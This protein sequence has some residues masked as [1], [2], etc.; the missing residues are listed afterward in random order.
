MAAG[1]RP[2]PILAGCCPGPP[3]TMD[4]VTL[5]AY[6]FVTY[7]RWPSGVTAR[8]RAPGIEPSS[9]SRLPPFLHGCSTRKGS[10]LLSAVPTRTVTSLLRVDSGTVTTSARSSA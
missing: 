7:T 8:S 1:T 5:F 4:T 6:G 2:T 3:V 9:P 10:A